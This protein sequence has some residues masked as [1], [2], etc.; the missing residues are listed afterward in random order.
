MS[1][2]GMSAAAINLLQQRYI[3]TA[4]LVTI[5]LAAGTTRM[6]DWARPVSW[7]GNDYL[8]V[9]HM[10]GLTP[11]IETGSMEITSV[12]LTLTGVDSVW[13]SALLGYDYINTR[14]TIS[15][16]FF[17]YTN[18]LVDVLQIF[19]GRLDAAA[20]NEDPGS[21]TVT[22]AATA[23]SDMG[24]IDGKRGR[25]TNDAQQRAL[26]PGDKGF[27]FITGTPRTIYWGQKNPT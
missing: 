16:A 20:V 11:V 27:E 24:D 14:T 6:T 4:H 21:G 22:V 9:G 25:H 5:E 12:S 23:N 2:R 26:Y 19:S 3:Y 15:R 18:D 17:N 7:D 10:L 13:I 1:D 8:A